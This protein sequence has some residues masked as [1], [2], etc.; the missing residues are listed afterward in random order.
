MLLLL[1]FSSGLVE[2]CHGAII[3]RSCARLKLK[4]DYGVTLNKNLLNKNLF[5]CVCIC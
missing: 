1:V 4:L 3:V 2:N 5:S